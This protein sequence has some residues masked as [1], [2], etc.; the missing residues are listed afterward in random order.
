MNPGFKIWWNVQ[1]FIA[2]TYF[3]KSCRPF[4]WTLSQFCSH[5]NFVY[6]TDLTV[7]FYNMPVFKSTLQ[8][9]FSAWKHWPHSGKDEVYK[10]AT[11]HHDVKIWQDASCV[12]DFFFAQFSVWQVLAS[13]LHWIEANNVS[14]LTLDDAVQ[15]SK[16]FTWHGPSLTSVVRCH[17]HSCCLH[18]CSSHDLHGT[19]SD[20]EE[21]EVE[22]ENP[23]ATF[24]LSVAFG[25]YQEKARKQ[26][27]CYYI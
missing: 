1:Y 15:R 20:M 13:V 12:I 5:D 22:I 18:G 8:D 19:G 4:K 10:C 25:F 11:V 3:S 26:W 6:S 9:S 14:F 27:E 24:K 2:I 23:P 21:A 16:H 17:R 7:C